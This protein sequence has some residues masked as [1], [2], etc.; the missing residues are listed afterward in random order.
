MTV[1]AYRWL[2]DNPPVL[3]IRPSPF[4]FHAL[5][6]LVRSSHTTMPSHRPVVELYPWVDLYPDLQLRAI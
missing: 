1:L 6:E 2:D 5:A 3:V 4:G